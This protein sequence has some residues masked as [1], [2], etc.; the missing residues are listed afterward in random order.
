MGPGSFDFIF[1]SDLEEVGG[2]GISAWKSFSILSVTNV[3]NE[4]GIWFIIFFPISTSDLF[5][6]EIG[7]LTEVGLFPDLFDSFDEGRFPQ[8]FSILNSPFT[9]MFIE[10][11]YSY[12]E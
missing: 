7:R 4:S 11:N 9:K 2:G 1:L 3:S 5:Y 6:L 12:K 8:L 10:L